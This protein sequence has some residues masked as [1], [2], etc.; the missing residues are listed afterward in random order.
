VTVKQQINGRVEWA[1]TLVE[2]AKALIEAWGRT[3]PYRVDVERDLSTGLY[4]FWLRGVKPTPPELGFVVADA[5]HNLRSALDN[6]MWALR[7]P[8]VTDERTL[9]SISF[10]HAPDEHAW[11]SWEGTVKTAVAVDILADLHDFQPYLGYN[12]ARDAY[13]GLDALWQASKHRIP[14]FALASLRPVLAM[15]LIVKGNMDIAGPPGPFHEGD[16]IA[17]GRPHPGP[18]PEVEPHFTMELAFER[19]GPCP[20]VPVYSSIVDLHHQV[21]EAI[22]PRFLARL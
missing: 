15:V 19:G 6:T 22:L 21:R 4:S 10:F 12:P 17:E 2:K 3:D 1:W 8:N 5:V 20:G 7:D 14:T 13:A 11:K 9:R 18:L 16:K